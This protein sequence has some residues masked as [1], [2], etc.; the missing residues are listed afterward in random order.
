M[1]LNVLTERIATNDKMILDIQYQIKNLEEELYNTTLWKNIQEAKAILNE[2]RLSIE[3][4]KEITMEIMLEK[5]LKKVEMFDRVFTLKE[6]PWAIKVTD[7]NL[8]PEKYF[9]EKVSR[10]LDKAKLKEWI[11]DWDIVPWA[12]IEKSYSLI[13]KFKNDDK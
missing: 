12:N 11:K 9:V 2:T 3:K 5:W 6:S 7:E 8:I 10:Q 13:I 4:E 1:N